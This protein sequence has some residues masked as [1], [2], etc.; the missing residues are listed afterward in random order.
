M[1]RGHRSIDEA[2]RTFDTALDSVG[3]RASRIPVRVVFELKQR[4]PALVGLAGR[5]AR[6]VRRRPT[7]VRRSMG[8]SSPP[9]SA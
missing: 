3:W 7:R 2:V 4:A 1:Y 9:D 5:V 6:S 8:G